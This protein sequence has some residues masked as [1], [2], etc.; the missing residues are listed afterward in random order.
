MCVVL[1]LRYSTKCS[2]QI[3]E[4]QFEAAI[5]VFLCGTPMWRPEN[6]VSVWNLPRLFRTLI[7]FTE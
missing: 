5:L 7:D 1:K 3:Y 6:S 2:A 4:A